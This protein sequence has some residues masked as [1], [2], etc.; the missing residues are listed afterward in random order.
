LRKVASCLSQGTLSAAL[1]A[2]LTGSLLTS[3]AAW[4]MLLILALTIASTWLLI[5]RLEADRQTTEFSALTGMAFVMPRWFTVLAVSVGLMS[6]IPLASL[7]SGQVIPEL[8]ELGRWGWPNMALLMGGF[9]GSWAAVRMLLQLGF[10]T[11][12]ELSQDERAIRRSS[13]MHLAS[14]R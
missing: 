2:G 6:A 3:L 14:L 7:I 8:L 13:L 4:Q 11:I 1:I 10:G 5:G 12:G 9:L